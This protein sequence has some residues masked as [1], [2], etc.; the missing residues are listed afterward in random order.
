MSRADKVEPDRL[1]NLVVYPRAPTLI[2]VRVDRDLDADNGAVWAL[3]V[4]DEVG[5]V[6]ALGQS[7]GIFKH[8]GL[9]ESG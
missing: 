3:K 6:R 4:N 7:A 9:P 5:V 2:T 8:S 1:V